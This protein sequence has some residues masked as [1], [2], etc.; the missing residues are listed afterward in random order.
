MPKIDWEED[1]WDDLDDEFDVPPGQ[2]AKPVNNRMGTLNRQ[3]GIINRYRKQKLL[4]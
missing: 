4:K 1:E 3:Q 2:V